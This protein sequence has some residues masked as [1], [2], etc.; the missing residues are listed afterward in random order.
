MRVLSI[1]AWY[2]AAT[3]PLTYPY[4]PDARPKPCPASG[5][6][7]P[8]DPVTVSLIIPYL[9]E[10]WPEMRH[11]VASVLD[12]TPPAFLEEMI[13]ISDGNEEGHI[14]EDDLKALSPKIKLIKFDERRGLIRAKT[15]GAQQAVGKVIL[16]FEPHCIVGES[17]LEPLLW[18]LQNNPNA[19]VLPILDLLSQDD[20]TQYSSSMIGNYR[21]EWNFNLQFTQILGI[22]DW[23][24]T[25]FYG[26]ASSGGILALYKERFE[27]LRLFDLGLDEWGGDQVELSF[28]SWRCGGAI[29]VVPC[30]RVGH[31]FRDV[32]HRHYDVNV[33]KVVH[34]YVRL[35]RVWLDDEIS[36]E[37][38]YKVKPE[39]RVMDTG[40]L[41]QLV[42]DKEELKCKSFRWYLKNV[43][44]QQAW[45]ES[46]LCNGL[47]VHGAP[48][49]TTVEGNA[50]TFADWFPLAVQSEVISP[51]HAW[52]DREQL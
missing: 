33:T 42:K 47:C 27:E 12:R 10:G 40:D 23:Y 25:P 43:D 49:T 20:P 44:F 7:Y 37:N 30:S 29:I 26:S 3:E 11:M 51:S 28:K 22:K 39:S 32:K 50:M 9:H 41:S 8:L 18:V 1:V 2:S 15:F 6:D 13:F 24:P 34:N 46:R 4:P 21:I 38:F 17:W 48:G 31:M 36:M 19:T 35:A 5:S 52:R 45:D 14:F 16:F